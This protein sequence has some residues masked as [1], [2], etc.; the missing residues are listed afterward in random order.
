MYSGVEIPLPRPLSQSLK[1]AIGRR[2]VVTGSTYSFK[3]TF[4]M[5]CSDNTNGGRTLTAGMTVPSP[6]TIESCTTACFNAGMQYA[7]AEYSGECCKFLNSLYR[8]D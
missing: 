3:S 5:V 8:G 7:G 6:V 4:L 2:L 1:S